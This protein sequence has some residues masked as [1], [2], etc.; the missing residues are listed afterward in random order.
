M[1]VLFVCPYLPSLIRVR[2]YNFIKALAK[3]GHRISLLCLVQARHEHRDADHLREYCEQTKTVYMGQVRSV[4]SC[5]VHCASSVA[6][7]AAYCF[8]REMHDEVRRTL[9]EDHFDVVHVEHIRG[10]HFL[11]SGTNVPSVFDSVDCITS[12][13]EQFSREKPSLLGR[14][15]SKVEYRRLQSYE[16][17]EAAK[18]ERVIVTSQRDKEELLKLDP[19][20]RIDVISNGVDMEYFHPAESPP[21]TPNIVFSGKMSYYA[22]ESAAASLCDEIMP[23]IRAREPEATLTIAGSSPSKRVRRYGLAPGIEVTG[24]VP[25]IRVPIQKARVAV[26]PVSV[27]AGVQN[28]VLEA[29]AMARAVVA[30]SKA[31]QALSVRNGEDLL[32]ADEPKA[33]AEAVVRLLR[34]D[35]LALKLGQNGRKYVERN[36]SWD[37]NARLLEEAYHKAIA[38]ISEKGRGE[39]EP[40]CHLSETCTT[41]R[42][43]QQI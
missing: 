21:E 26:C 17:K 38:S 3:R 9:S 2:P 23:L 39:V 36:H 20:L 30:T 31:C 22:N 41:T 1:R 4:S 6:I 34:D 15:A 42:Y 5:L 13:Y 18:F 12:L 29:M 27:G 35:K 14:W 40:T 24:H 43:R 8:S 7:Q 28:K 10:A 33:F 19:H 25:D 11:P 16:P 37:D 32:I